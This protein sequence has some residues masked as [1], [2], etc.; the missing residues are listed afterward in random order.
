VLVVD[1]EQDLGLCL[2]EILEQDGHC[3]DYVASAAIALEK[4]KRHRYEVILSDIRMP[5]MDGPSFFRT[6]RSRHPDQLGGFAFIT[7]DTLTP[8]LKDFIDSTERPCIEKPFA[9]RDVR[10]VVDLILRSQSR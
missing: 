4:L 8:Q 5:G 3:V 7:G 10:Q 2:A 1:D 6:L 9:P